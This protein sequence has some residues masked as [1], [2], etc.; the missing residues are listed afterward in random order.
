M[1]RSLTLIVPLVALA[2]PIIFAQD[3]G[4]RPAEP[5]RPA[6]PAAPAAP[7][8]PPAPLRDDTADTVAQLGSMDA[9]DGTRP[10][11]IGDQVALRIVEEGEKVASYVVQ[12]SGNIMAPFIG[13]VP[14]AGKTPK[15][16][17]FYMKRELQKRH[18]RSATVI[19]ALEKPAPMEFKGPG[20]NRGPAMG[21]VTIYGQVLRQGR[22]EVDPGED[23]TVSQAVLRAGGLAQF[24]KDTKVKVIRKS[25][26][27]QNV[28]IYVNL[29]DI[30][31]KGKLEYDIPIR[32]GDTIIVDEKI[33]NF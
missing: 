28:T 13:L 32:A 11:Q 8:I 15:D 23:L 16:V 3:P 9:L 30:M 20:V 24:A 5:L 1:K 14:A 33:F 25:P 12:A 26:S 29:R 10:L 27:K 4:F 17:A 22:Y 7:A 18:F 6:A 31:M 2:A 21:Y 19:L